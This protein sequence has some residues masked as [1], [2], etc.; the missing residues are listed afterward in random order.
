VSRADP[1]RA[2]LD[3]DII[4]SRV[5][6]D[7]MGRVAADLRMLDLVWSDQLLAEVKGSLIQRKGLA[8][9]VAQRWVGYLPQS[10]PAGRTSIDE[11]LGS[12]DL[13]SLT[14]DPDDRHVCALAIASSADYLFTHDRGYLRDALE[15]RGIEVIRPEGFLLLAFEEQPRAMLDVLELQASTWAGG[16]PIDE[17]LDAIDRAGAA[18]FADMA[19]TSLD[20]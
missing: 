9:E 20:T 14:V 7:L 15:T 18:E 12:G 8:E 17:L 13:A 5:L 10:F 3:A 2:V 19:R 16:R 6:H 11:A 1:P 4:F